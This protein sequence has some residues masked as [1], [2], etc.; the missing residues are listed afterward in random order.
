MENYVSQAL[1]QSVGRDGTH[2][3]FV[4]GSDGGW[5][6]TRDGNEVGRGTGEQPSIDAGVQKFLS[7]TRVIVG[8]KAACDPVVGAMLDRI[9]RG[10]SA[11][12]KVAKYQGGIKP[13]A[14][15]G[16]SAHLTRCGTASP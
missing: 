5:A 15:K 6:I 4:V 2:W 9:E 14:S 10:R 12:V 8:S 3:L 16:S 7:L 1:F 13:H 11:T